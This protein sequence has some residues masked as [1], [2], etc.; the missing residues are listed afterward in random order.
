MIT[1]NF[2]INC[3][4]TID[5]VSNEIQ[6]YGPPAPLIKGRM[7]A[8]SQIVQRAETVEVHRE[9][10]Q[11]HKKV[12]LYIDLCYINIMIFLITR[13]DEIS[14]ITIDNI[15]KKPKVKSLKHF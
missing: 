14:Y 11:V 9:I 5:D 1:K 2:L 15:N 6:I 8:P 4:L 3:K 7:T 12:Q 13:S 10:L